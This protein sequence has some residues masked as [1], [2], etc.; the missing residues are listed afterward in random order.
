MDAAALALKRLV[1]TDGIKK[2]VDAVILGAGSAVAGKVGIDQTTPGTTD[3]VTVA[4][5]QGAGATIGLAA[6][7]SV[8]T[9][10]VGTLSGKLRGA[11]ANLA[12]TLTR[13]GLAAD[14][15]VIT[16]ADGSLH[17]KARGLVSLLNQVDATL[18]AMTLKLPAS[19]GGKAGSGS[20]SELP[21]GGDALGN[22]QVS[23]GIASQEIVAARVGRLAV[24]IRN[25]DAAETIYVGA[26]TVS[27]ANGAPLYPYDAITIPTQAAING[28]ADGTTSSI[29]YLEV[30]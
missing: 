29:A 27:N 7:A 6:D 30:Y 26:G 4:T 28:I 5:G 1:E 8:P 24:H 25:L 22:N 9:D 10:A 13:L 19:L 11:V 20:L 2:I 12:S 18:D 15:A 3:S 21:V 23:V 16:D 17:A 14:A